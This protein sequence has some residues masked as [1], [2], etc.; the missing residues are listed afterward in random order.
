LFCELLVNVLYA[1]FMVRWKSRSL[2]SIIAIFGAVV[3]AEKYY[4]LTAGDAFGPWSVLLD[5]VPRAIFSFF[6]GVL[7][8]RLAPRRSYAGSPIIIL[9]LIVI[10]A[11]NFGEQFQPIYELL[12]IVFAFPALVFYASST[13][14]NGRLSRV[15]VLLGAISYPAFVIHMPAVLW[16][17]AIFP[18]VFGKNIATIAPWG[19][20]ALIALIIFVSYFLDRTYDEPVRRWL[21]QRVTRQITSATHGLNP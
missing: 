5:G 2:F 17:S 13:N 7:L 12:L 14:V 8:Y 4:L 9:L 21:K 18:R 10:F 11:L 20:L 16:V 15:Y 1:L 19:G 3:F 6:A